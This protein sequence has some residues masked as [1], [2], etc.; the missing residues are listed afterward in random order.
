MTYLPPYAVLWIAFLIP[1]PAQ[2]RAVVWRLGTI[3][4]ALVILALIGVPVYLAATAMTSA[5]GDNWPAIFH[6][7]W[8]L[9]SPAYWQD[10]VS[11]FP[12]CVNH[13]QLMCASTPIGW[14]EFAALVGAVYLAFAGSG[15]RRRYGV[16]IIALLAGLH[17]YAMISMGLVLGRLHVVSGPYLMWAFFPLAG[18]AAIAA[19]SFIAGSIAGR[20]AARW[21]PAVASCLIA[22]AA[23]LVWVKIILP[24]QPRLP[25]RGPLGFPPIA[26]I[27]INKGP[28][29]EYLQQHIGL[30]PG[31]E[32]RGY[33]STF[34]GP[35][36]GLVRKL[37][38]TPSDIM[39]WNAYIAAR[40][41]LFDHFGNSFQST[42]L[43][44]SGIPTLEEYGQWTSRQMYYFNRDLLAEPQ[45]QIDTMPNSILVYRFRPSLLRVLGVR[46]V[47]ADGTLTD[48][49]IELV[50][51]ESG[52]ADSKVN[53]YEIKGANLGQFSP[54]Q[55]TWAAD[56]SAALA[57]MREQ[58]DLEK[59]VVRLGAPEPNPEVVSAS[60][61]R[62]VAISDGYHLTAAAPGQAMLQ[63]PIQ[64]SHCW[65][66]EN[67]G[68]T[69]SP[70]VFRANIVQ[71]GILFKGNLDIR[72]RFNFE[73]WRASCRL[74]DARD[75]SQFGF[76]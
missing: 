51:T 69:G 66:V 71:T 47:I 1:F 41:I 33:A 73:P 40:D 58:G 19:G 11:I 29:V 42:D 7:G 62:L 65:Q 56:Y 54:T 64:F 21:M 9:L 15:A 60:R 14:F 49:S 46:F 74:Q 10:L 23:I 26:Q 43:W 5:R 45:D 8:R 39:T 18:P 25:G 38:K 17:F 37:T 32:F 50:M 63:L 6:P 44:N 13:F 4:F 61:A 48:P 75:L 24:N 28:I 3:A 36:D 20:R 52:K 12:V 30:K 22:A 55:V 34:L 68:N 27:P 16:V 53:L 72:L 76:K 67:E 31:G 2:R 35:H 57:A 70:R 59:R